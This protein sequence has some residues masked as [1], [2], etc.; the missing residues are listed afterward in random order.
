MTISLG[1]Q[2]PKWADDL[3]SLVDQELLLKLWEE[4]ASHEAT[5]SGL[6]PNPKGS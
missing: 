1:E 3:R 6:D 4:V 2:R 5:F